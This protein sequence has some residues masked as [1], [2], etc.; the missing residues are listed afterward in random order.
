MKLQSK[1]SL[2]REGTLNKFYTRDVIGQLITDEMVGLSPRK[3]IDLGAGEGSL[4]IA[5]GK[6]WP[7]ISIVTVDIDAECVEDLHNRLTSTGVTQHI[8]HV[9]DV[10]QIDL[11]KALEE[12]GCFDLAVCNPPFFRP[13]W[14]RDFSSIL[15]KAGL[16]NAC[17]SVSEVTAEILFLA[18]NLRLL[19]KGGMIALIVPD[20][21]LT[22]S[23]MRA[24]RQTILNKHRV[25]CVMQLP[26]H[27]FHDTEARCF[28]LF[29]TKDAGP[30]KQVK[31]LRYDNSY[32]LSNP[33]F[34]DSERAEKRM[35]FD[36]HADS[37]NDDGQVSTL[38][39]MGAHVIRGSISTV[40]AKKA[41][42]PVFHTTNYKDTGNR[43]KL[44]DSLDH[45]LLQKHV[46][47]EAGDILMARVDRSLHQK[48]AIVESGKAV[49]TDCVYRVRLPTGAR[50][51]A[52]EALCSSEGMIKL[53]AVSKGVSARLLGKADLLDLPLHM[54]T[55]VA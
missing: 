34:I 15:Q 23:R 45:S 13:D 31:L 36:Y 3:S 14:N 37:I 42:F 21:I 51:A 30:T 46:I 5:V 43:L 52:F 47:A 11:P 48:V 20:G 6:A 8:H 27:S 53:K 40:E 1:F 26:P 19:K 25:D 9:N 55:A 35:D 44:A 22:G 33:I 4:S 12:H 2:L 17:N 10:M 29:L 39:Q 16:E 49:L 32:G 41:D 24:L 28:V 7:D 50:E 38:R 18:Q 54:T